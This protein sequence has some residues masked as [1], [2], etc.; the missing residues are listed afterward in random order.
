MRVLQVTKT[1]EGSFWAVRQVEHLVMHG[2]EV[3]A[4]LPSSTGAA[5]D[6]W[7]ASGATLHFVDCSLPIRTP[8]AVLQR[9]SQIRR[10]VESVQPDLIHT[11]HV[12]TTAMLRLALGNEYS[13]PRLFQ[14]PGPLH[15]EHWHTRTFE[16]VLAG[17]ND[18]WIASSRFIMELYE[19]A[20]IAS[21]KLFLSYNTTDTTLFSNVRT[22][23]LRHKLGIPEH[24]LIVGNIN[25][26]YPPKRYL[27]HSV[28]L[29]CHEDIIEALRI[30]QQQRND[31]WGVLAGGTFGTSNTYERK[32]NTLAE[33]KGAGRILMPGNLSPQ[34]VAWSWPDFDCAIHAPLSENCGGV[35]EPLL[36]GVP[37]IAGDVGGLPEVVHRG[38]TGEL[39]PIRDPELLAEAVLNVFDRYDEFRQMAQQGMQL[40]NVMFDSKRCSNEVLSIYRHLLFNESRPDAFNSEQFLILQRQLHLVEAPAL[41]FK[42]AALIS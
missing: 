8:A 6:A 7:R 18:F 23:Y 13:V 9:A 12:T 24:A 5:V 1:S 2:V 41:P 34:E 42:T 20:G 30:I 22:G 31:V 16:I 33:Q 21:N 17:E 27:G 40:A 15:M 35:V 32:L 36:S 19:K 10:L 25:L 37:I 3:H 11:H 4:V 14:V 29:K 28:G 26:I 39:V 38:L